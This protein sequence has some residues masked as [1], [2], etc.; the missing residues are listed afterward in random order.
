MQ[1]NSFDKIYMGPE[2]THSGP[3]YHKQNL[4][5]NTSVWIYNAKELKA[6][7][8]SGKVSFE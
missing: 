8:N 6:V 2:N 7:F 3:F 1:K 4:P 5:V